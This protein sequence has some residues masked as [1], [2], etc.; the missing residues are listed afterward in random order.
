[1]TNL[2]ESQQRFKAHREGGQHILP[3]ERRA[4]IGVELRDNVFGAF[5]L[6][7]PNSLKLIYP[8]KRELTYRLGDYHDQFMLTMQWVNPDGQFKSATYRKQ[9]VTDPNDTA[10]DILVHDF[11]A[12]NPGWEGE[13]K[14]FVNTM[15]AVDV[16]N[17]TLIK[18]LPKNH[19]KQISG[20]SLEEIED[21]IS[22][23]KGYLAPLMEA[24][25]Q[26]FIQRLFNEHN[27]NQDK[28]IYVSIIYKDRSSVVY[29][30][31]YD[32]TSIIQV[33]KH[34]R[35][36]ALARGTFTKLKTESRPLW[37]SDVLLTDKFAYSLEHYQSGA[38][39]RVLPMRVDGIYAFDPYLN[40]MNE[41]FE[42]N[43]SFREELS[44]I[45]G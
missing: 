23:S 28:P 15:K 13:P 31:S 17:E 11:E 41:I 3:I 6:Y 16:F 20:P 34:G 37:R 36:S 14:N 22:S 32:D 9:L 5:N 21:Q 42:N 2:T 35:D 8:D 30:S 27:L 29:N 24:C 39:Q 44:E 38:K 25:G 4:Q 12:D 26:Y 1:M 45:K 10:H 19:E 43:N 40:L 7:R 18:K 33:S